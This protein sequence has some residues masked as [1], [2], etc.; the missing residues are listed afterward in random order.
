MMPQNPKSESVGTKP[1]PSGSAL[2][3]SL[4]LPL[5]LSL[6]AL[7]YVGVGFLLPWWGFVMPS[8]L[9][10]LWMAPRK[11]LPLWMGALG[12]VNWVFVAFIE[13]FGTGF[14]LSSRLAGVVALPSGALLYPILVLLAGSL[15]ALACWTGQ[16]IRSLLEQGI[17]PNP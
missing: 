15:A 3:F 16:T 8:A 2:S 1:K 14:R 9:A 5:G 11:R 17:P 13:D 12:A 6:T 7:L 10:G 4:G